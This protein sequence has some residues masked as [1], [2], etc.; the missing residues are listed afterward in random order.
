MTPEGAFSMRQSRALFLLLALSG[1]LALPA[2]A[3][4]PTPQKV[5]ERIEIA[6]PPAAVW[7]IAKDFAGIASWHPLVEKSA[8]KGGSA[9]GAEREVTL[10]SGG[11]LADGLDDFN[12][13]EMSYGYRLAKENVD[14]FPVS[15][16]SATLTVKPNDSGGSEVEW[17]GRFYRADTSNFPPENKNDAAAVAAMKSFFSEGLKGLKAKAE[18]N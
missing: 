1:C 7:A 14:A 12:E 3:H 15:F 13:Q 8:G 4:G 5:E 18:A 9:A 10:K 6:A 11:V 16:Y 17:I 2:A